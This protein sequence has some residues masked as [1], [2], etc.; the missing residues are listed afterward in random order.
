MWEGGKFV[1][2]LLFMFARVCLADR[3]DRCGDA[4]AVRVEVCPGDKLG[5]AE[6]VGLTVD[7]RDQYGE[8]VAGELL[9][10]GGVLAVD[11]PL[12]GT[13]TARQ[14]ER[15][16]DLD[17]DGVLAQDGGDLAKPRAIVCQSTLLRQRLQTVTSTA[18]EGAALKTSTPACAQ[19]IQ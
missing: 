3:A 5:R 11:M 7:Q 19:V 17:P 14:R 1:L 8:A 12:L 9:P 18:A 13:G 16:A 2:L 6:L 4:D 15:R 10:P